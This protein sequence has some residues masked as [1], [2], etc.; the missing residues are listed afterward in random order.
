[1][2]T[3]ALCCPSSPSPAAPWAHAALP[4]PAAAVCGVGRWPASGAAG[5]RLAAAPPLFLGMCA[6][7]LTPPPHSR[8]RARRRKEHLWPYVREFSD[9]AIEHVTSTMGKL[10][11]MGEP[12]ELYDIHG[13]YAGA[14]QCCFPP[15]GR[16][17]SALPMAGWCSSPAASALCLACSA[18]FPGHVQC[19]TLLMSYHCRCRRGRRAHQ[20]HA[21]C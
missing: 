11:A 18:P 5:C 16:P 21:G 13:H 7:R 17:A 8:A 4:A 1:V 19:F 10:M 6:A 12:C 20:L 2:S 14:R 15:R 9:N 3:A